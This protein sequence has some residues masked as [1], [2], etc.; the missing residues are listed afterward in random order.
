MPAVQV[1]KVNA[2]LGQASMTPFQISADG[3]FVLQFV[4]RRSIAPHRNDR[5]N[6]QTSPMLRAFTRNREVAACSDLQ[7]SSSS[8]CHWSR[9]GHDVVL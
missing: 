1:R 9:F 6:R 3:M 7:Y 8:F 2:R 4:C 5:E